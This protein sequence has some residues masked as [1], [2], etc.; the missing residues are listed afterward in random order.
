MVCPILISVAVT[1]RISALA[2]TV[3]AS[4][5]RALAA[6]HLTDRRIVSSPCRI[7]ERLRPAVRRLQA[8]P[9]IER[10]HDVAASAMASAE[11]PMQR[12]VLRRNG[13]DCRSEFTKAYQ[14]DGSL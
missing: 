12:R 2:T 14:A 3:E 9:F 11:I 5:A 7:L 4:R 10:C 1:P 6:H 13:G 8:P